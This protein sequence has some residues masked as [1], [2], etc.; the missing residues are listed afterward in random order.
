MSW[1]V[2]PGIDNSKKSGLLET[3]Q[4]FRNPTFK[5]VASRVQFKRGK[6]EIQNPESNY[7]VMYSLAG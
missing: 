5:N 2:E 7:R 3:L 6:K 1:Y 4:P